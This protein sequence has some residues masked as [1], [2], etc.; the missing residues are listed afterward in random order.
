MARLQKIVDYH[1]N[2]LYY[3]AVKAFE[4]SKKILKFHGH[5]RYMY[6]NHKFYFWYKTIKWMLC[7]LPTFIPCWLNRKSDLEY[8]INT[9]WDCKY[10]MKIQDK[11]EERLNKYVTRKT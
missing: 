7:D 6:R 11:L 9:Y 1:R 4:K 5:I 3:D 8:F 2:E 10:R